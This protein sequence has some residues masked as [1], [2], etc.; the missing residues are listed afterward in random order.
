MTNTTASTK[1]GSKFIAGIGAAILAGALCLGGSATAF[2]DDEQVDT[3]SYGYLTAQQHVSDR[4]ATSEEVAADADGNTDSDGNAY[5]EGVEYS[6]KTG[7]AAGASYADAEHTDA[8]DLVAAGIIE[9][10]DEIDAYAAAKHADISSRFGGLDSMSPTE[11]HEHFS[12]FSQDAYA[13]DTL[14]ELQAQGLAE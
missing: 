12:Q 1:T 9:S 10:T 7:A 2:A 13:G 3:E 4:M 5:A 8:E 11:R 6:Y 14:E